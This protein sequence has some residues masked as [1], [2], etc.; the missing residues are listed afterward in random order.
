MPTSEEAHSII[1]R[2][3]ASHDCESPEGHIVAGGPLSAEPHERGIGALRP[4]EQIVIDIFPRSKKTGYFADMTRTMCLGAPSVQLQKMYDAVLGAQEL[5]ISMARPGAACKDLQDAVEKYFV[6]AG[7]ITSGKGKEFT[8]AEGFVHSVGHGVGLEIHE[9][10]RFGRHSDDILIEGD[11]ITI[12]PGLYYKDF[13]G[14][15]IEDMVLVTHEGYRNLT[16]CS[17][18]FVL[19]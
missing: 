2:V 15:R 11:V 14:I 10:P 6:D 7:F 12:E 13:G 17:K 16:S 3:L 9:A 8:Y 1:D 19:D 18:E 4:G 5:A